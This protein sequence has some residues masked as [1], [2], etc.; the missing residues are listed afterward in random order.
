MWP[1]EF[2][3]SSHF[4]LNSFWWLY[5]LWLYDK[6]PFET[7][8]EAVWEMKTRHKNASSPLA[9]KNSRVGFPAD[10]EWQMIGTLYFNARSSLKK[11]V[12]I[13]CNM[14]AGEIWAPTGN[15]K[16]LEQSQIKCGSEANLMF[17]DVFLRLL[18]VF[19]TDV[20]RCKI[21]TSF[22]QS[23]DFLMIFRQP[24]VHAEQIVAFGAPCLERFPWFVLNRMN[25]DTDQDE[26]RKSEIIST[27]AFIFKVLKNYGRI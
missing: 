24:I 5:V 19:G 8:K 7:S 6:K 14:R 4:L 18:I 12:S 10:R 17:E 22:A 2:F 15:M 9:I 20:S 26:I 27:P 13:L 23:D 21:E 11:W 1:W 16:R 25:A 3:K